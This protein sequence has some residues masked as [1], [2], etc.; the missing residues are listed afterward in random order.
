VPAYPLRAALAGIVL[1]VAGLALAGGLYQINS[2]EQDRFRGWRGADGTVVEL[3]K[4]PAESGLLIPLIAFTTAS[5]ERVSFTATTRRRE[6][7]YYLNAP[8]RIVYDPAHPQDALIDARARRWTRNTLGSGSALILIGLGGYVAW[9]AS[10]L[11][12]TAHLPGEP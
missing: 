10:R 9:Y 5:G 8:V 2:Q 7:P 12:R 6:S 11:D 1:F 4:G 3:L